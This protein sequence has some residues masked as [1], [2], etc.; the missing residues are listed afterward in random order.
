MLHRAKFT[1][2]SPTTFGGGTFVTMRRTFKKTWMTE[3][4]M[5]VKKPFEDTAVKLAAIFIPRCSEKMFRPILQ[6]FSI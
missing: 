4:H 2:T 5:I 6:G 3:R 1:Q